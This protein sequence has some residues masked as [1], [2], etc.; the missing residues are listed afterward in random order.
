[1]FGVAVSRG[2][3]EGFAR[4]FIFRE[5]KDFLVKILL[6]N[7]SVSSSSEN[8]VVLFVAFL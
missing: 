8:P 6:E 4:Y 5:Q 2:S 3:S 7:L 1:M